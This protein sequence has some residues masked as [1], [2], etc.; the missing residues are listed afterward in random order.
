MGT[1]VPPTGQ[2]WQTAPH[3]YHHLIIDL[4]EGRGEE[5]DVWIVD[6]TRAVKDTK[7]DAWISL[8]KV[9]SSIVFS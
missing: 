2:Q 1:P 9:F 8:Q 7:R 6:S 3:E 4:K 5:E